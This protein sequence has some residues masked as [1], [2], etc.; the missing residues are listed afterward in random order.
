MENQRMRYKV[1]RIKKGIKLIDV[2]KAIDCSH[3]LISLYESNKC[4]MS[5]DKV[6]KYKAYIEEYKV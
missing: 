4:D 5:L 3:S 2:A 6:R 1:M